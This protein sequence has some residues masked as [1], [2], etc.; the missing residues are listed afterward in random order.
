MGIELY[1]FISL[2]HENNFVKLNMENSPQLLTQIQLCKERKYFNQGQIMIRILASLSK[3]GS[4]GATC[5]AIQHLSCIKSQDFNRFKYFLQT[6]CKLNL[7]QSFYE[8][9]SGKNKRI[10]Y[11]ILERGIVLVNIYKSHGF[12]EIFGS[13][14]D[15][16]NE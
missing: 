7:I 1:I 2:P 3:I 11:K 6:L 8:V 12:S 16:Y 14:D 15:I 9:T 13:I 4:T 10:K 5:Y